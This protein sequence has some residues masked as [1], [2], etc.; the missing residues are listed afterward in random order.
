[1]H[2]DLL[3]TKDQTFAAYKAYMAW[4]KT[5]HGTHIKSLCSDHGG[6]FLSNKFTNFLWEQGMEHHLT[7]HD[8][9]QH[10]GIAES[11]NQWLV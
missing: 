7:T 10:N 8:T 6:E 11:L 5:Q 4:V 9:P 2:L 3:K 1:M